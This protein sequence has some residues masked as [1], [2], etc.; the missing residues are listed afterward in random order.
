MNRL[1]KIAVNVV[2][3]LCCVLSTVSVNAE[4]VEGLVSKLG[5]EI[6][7]ESTTTVKQSTEII[8]TTGTYVDYM[9][10]WN[11]TVS[12]MY[13]SNN[14]AAI[15]DILSK[16][17]SLTN[18]NKAL[19]QAISDELLTADIDTLLTYDRSYKTNTTNSNL[20]LKN[21]DFY[22]HSYEMQDYIYEVTVYAEVPTSYVTDAIYMPNVDS[23]DIGS[24]QPS[25]I[26]DVPRDV[27]SEY[28]S[29]IDETDYSIKFHAGA[30]Y[31]C[32]IGT[33]V[34]SVFNGTI[35][36][37]GY[38]ANIGNFV[39]I[40]SGDNIKVLYTHL[41]EISV[42]DGDVV[43]QGDIIA[44]S[45]SSGSDCSHPYLHVALYI[46]GASYDIDKLWE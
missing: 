10:E 19:S 31:N 21:V 7:R 2:L 46:N 4:T 45:G 41:S 32:P 26:L 40:K 37:T 29:R 28:G 6:S 44:K 17:E 42:A 13:N 36:S 39:S 12:T 23:Y 1:K 18:N 14:E 38:S 27:Y 9:A 34:K 16:V 20:L 25:F 35:L 5:Y 43:S 22:K 8:E 24:L 15:E 30:D 33:N 11:N 3:L